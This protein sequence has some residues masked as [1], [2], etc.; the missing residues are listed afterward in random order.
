MR[1]IVFTLA[2]GIQL[3]AAAAGY[4]LLLLSMNA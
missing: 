2:A 3:A 1:V 4:V